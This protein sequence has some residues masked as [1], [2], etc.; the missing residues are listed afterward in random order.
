L[1][2][3][4]RPVA[5]VS[6][7]SPNDADFSAFET[8]RRPDVNAR[9]SKKLRVLATFFESA[10]PVFQPPLAANAIKRRKKTPRLR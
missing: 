5:T 9:R 7:D 4:R 3:E 10:V 1:E 6:R 8:T 2:K